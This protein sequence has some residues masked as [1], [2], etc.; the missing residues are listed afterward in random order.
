MYPAVAV[1][2]FFSNDERWVR[3]SKLE[4]VRRPEWDGW[5]VA[6]FTVSLG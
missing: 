1:S 4:S 3:R 5:P 6:S 2:F